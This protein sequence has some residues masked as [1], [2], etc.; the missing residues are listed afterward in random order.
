M[1]HY[2]NQRDEEAGTTLTEDEAMK[3]IKALLRDCDRDYKVA[4]AWLVNL[5]E[6]DE[7]K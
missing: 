6:G 2:G 5:Y 7:A 3:R 1:Q 4:K